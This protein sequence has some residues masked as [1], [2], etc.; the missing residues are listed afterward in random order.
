MILDS[1][2]RGILFDA[3][4]NQPIR[5]ARWADI[6]ADPGQ[7]G[8]YE[9][10]RIEPVAA[11]RAGIP[12]ESILYRGRARLR[13]IPAAPKYGRKPADVEP[14]GEARRRLGV[15]ALP[16]AVGVEC[17]EKG[18][19]RLAVWSVSDEKEIEPAV[20]PDGTREERAVCVGRR[21]YCDRHYRWPTFE[22][23]G[24][25]EREVTEIQARPQ[26]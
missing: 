17:Q 23:L 25:I 7:P 21:R 14:L 19:H 18:C 13:F 4:R 2:S 3:D 26:W 12:L 16:P 1:K 8:E 11:R 6:P 22:S 15:V 5:W 20:L 10:F 9:A 24:G